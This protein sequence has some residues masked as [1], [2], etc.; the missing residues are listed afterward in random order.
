MVRN[1]ERGL[2]KVSRLSF[3]SGILLLMSLSL[4][5][6]KIF[7]YAMEQRLQC[8]ECKKVGYRT[9]TAEVLSVAVPATEKGKDDDAKPVYA[10]V[11][12]TE[13]IE[14]VLGKEALE[15]ACPEC[16]KNVIATR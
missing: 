11:Q 1:T 4:D 7:S 6:T 16:K 13:C 3:S 14:G 9:D 15:Y 8:T 12:L 2:K 10:D 5:P